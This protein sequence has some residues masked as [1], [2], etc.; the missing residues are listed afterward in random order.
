MST[1]P[2]VSVVIPVYNGAKYVGEALESVFAQTLRPSEVIVVDDGSTDGTGE[3]VRGFETVTYVYQANAGASAARNLGVDRASGEYIAFLDHDDVWSPF[4]LERQ[5]ALLRDD[6]RVGFALCWIEHEFADGVPPQW[7]RNRDG[8]PTEPGYVTS[9]WLV[10]RA[11][12]DAVGPFDSAYRIGQDTDW[13][14][15]AVD[16]GIRYA[17]VGGD[18]LVTKRT[19]GSNLM[20][21]VQESKKEMLQLLRQSLRRKQG[22]AK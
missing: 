16:L 22:M 12:F 5:V 1:N 2:T 18:P 4:K 7:F 20:S 15:R 3:V 17:I 11:T 10:R 13:L 14:V 8:S 9:T 6:P 19:H 21:G